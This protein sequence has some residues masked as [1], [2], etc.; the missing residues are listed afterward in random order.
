M[1]M[2]ITA[3][4][5]AGYL[6]LLAAAII[7]VCLVGTENIVAFWRDVVEGSTHTLHFVALFI[8][9]PLVG[10]PVSV[11]LL[12]LG[13]KFGLA[14]AVAIMF[15]V[16]AIHVGVS[17]PA[18]NILLRP[19]IEKSLA[20]TTYRLPQ[21]RKDGFVW[22]SLVFMAV[23]GLSYSMKNYILA[24]SGVPFG[25]YFIIAW[26][27]QALLGIPLVAAGTMAD[28]GHFA[29]VAVLVFVFITLAAALHRWTVRRRT[30]RRN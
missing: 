17:F 12:L 8:V 25:F 19:L 6:L 4:S 23:P 2:N 9:L 18:A 5:A 22:P 30:A 7:A 27:V 16:M 21:F 24:L 11:F 1:G 10:F 15:G 28:R 13:A 3:K 14:Q 29:W 20:R 26:L